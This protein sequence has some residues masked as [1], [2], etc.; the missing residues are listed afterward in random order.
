M[1]EQQKEPGVYLAKDSKGDVVSVIVTPEGNILSGKRNDTE[2]YKIL[3][4]VPS[5]VVVN[6]MVKDMER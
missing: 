5:W 2:Q 4:K 1:K 3:S 6:A